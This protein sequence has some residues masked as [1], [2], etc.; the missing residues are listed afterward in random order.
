MHTSPKTERGGKVM[1]VD[2]WDEGRRTLGMRR[3]AVC[4]GFAV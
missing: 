3:V 4:C 1:L 2:V